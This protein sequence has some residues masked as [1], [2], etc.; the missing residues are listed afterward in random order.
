MYNLRKRYPLKDLSAKILEN[1]LIHSVWLGG[2]N[3]SFNTE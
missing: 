2:I 1:I 3:A